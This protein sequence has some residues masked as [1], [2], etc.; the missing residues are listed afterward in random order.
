MLHSADLRPL[1][2]GVAPADGGVYRLLQEGGAVLH[3]WR[4]DAAKK[5]KRQKK[6]DVVQKAMP[7]EE[8]KQVGETCRGPRCQRGDHR[9]CVGIGPVP[10]PS[11]S[12]G[13]TAQRREQ[14]K[15]EKKKRRIG[16]TCKFPGPS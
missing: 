4:R 10:V 7:P 1:P 3:K 14:Q 16:K 6:E 13:T 8:C 9:R 2:C 11:D 5:K 12:G 15:T